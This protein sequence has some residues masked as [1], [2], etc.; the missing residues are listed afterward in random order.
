MQAKFVTLAAIIAAATHVAVAAPVRPVALAPVHPT[1]SFDAINNF[2]ENAAESLLGDHTAKRDVDARSI[3]AIENFLGGLF[4]KRDEPLDAR[5]LTAIGNFFSNL[6]NKR[7]EL[8]ERSLTAIGNFISGLFNKRDEVDARSLTA[9]GNIF[10]S[11]FGYA[12]L[13]LR[14]IS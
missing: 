4:N 3:T 6:F 5:S 9:I 1:R 10:H 14:Y 8:D 13:H 12:F 11:I 7:D 2:I